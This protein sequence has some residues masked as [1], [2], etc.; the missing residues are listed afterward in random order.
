[1]KAWLR[2]AAGGAI[3]APRVLEDRELVVVE[4]QPAESA[5]FLSAGAAE[6]FHVSSEG[7]SVVVK[8][9][10]APTVLA[11]PEVLVAEPV[12]RASIRAA[13]AATVY[14]MS[15]ARFM[16]AMAEQDANMEATIDIALAFTGAARMEAARLV[17]SDSLLATLLLAYAD[18]FG[19]QQGEECVISLRRSQS[20]LAEAIGVAE[21]SVNRIMTRW[22]SEGW[23]GKRGGRYVVQN[24]GRLL[25][26]AGD[27]AGCIVHRWRDVT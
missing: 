8:L 7:F 15:R 25:E 16:G 17:E 11:S 4:G 9:V 13:G 18:V 1:V 23:V 22:K 10:T 24:R 21:R 20:D 12:H 2:L 27:L 26:L 6:I 5:Y 19:E 14:P 3:G